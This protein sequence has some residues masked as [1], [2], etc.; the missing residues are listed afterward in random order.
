MSTERTKAMGCDI[1]CAIERRDS[2]GCWHFVSP[3]PIRRNYELFGILAGVQGTRVPISLPRGLP[4]DYDQMDRTSADPD[5]YLDSD[6]GG[7]PDEFGDHSRSWLT[8]AELRAYDWAELVY[9]SC[10]EFVAWIRQQE[11]TGDDL[12]IV[13]GFDS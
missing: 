5:D 8:L 11:R 2:S 6:D 13:F 1:H 9:G 10:V 7:G 12:R 4:V 3:L